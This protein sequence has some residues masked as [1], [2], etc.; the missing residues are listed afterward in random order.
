MTG[1]KKYL[2]FAD[3][4]LSEAFCLYDDRDRFKP[5]EKHHSTALDTGRLAAQ[6]GVKNL[7][8]YHTEDKTLSTRK[9]KYTFEAAKAFKGCIYVPYD[10]EVI[11]F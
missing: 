2:E 4:L 3:W 5:Y 9:E 8:I 7:I 11:P 6:L 10:L 1:E